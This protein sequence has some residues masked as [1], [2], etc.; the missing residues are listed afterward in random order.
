MNSNET[1]NIK[2]CVAAAVILLYEFP[3]FTSLSFAM[4]LTVGKGIYYF[5]KLLPLNY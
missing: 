3:V 2:Y 1:A 4:T 5:C